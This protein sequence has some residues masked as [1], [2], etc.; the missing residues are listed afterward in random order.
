VENPEIQRL[1]ASPRLQQQLQ[2]ILEVDKLKTIL[3]QSRLIANG[4]RENSA[5]HS[6][7]LALMVMILAEHANEPADLLHTMKLVIVHDIVEIDAGDTFAYD[8]D[9][10]LDKREREEQAARRLFGILPADQAAEL[11]ALWH[12]FE[13]QA[14]PEARLANAV[15]RLMPLMHN[16]FTRG[17]SWQQHGVTRPQV[18]DRV[19]AIDDGS[20]ELW[21]FAAHLIDQAVA[22]GILA[23]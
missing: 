15:D 22:E 17:G 9:G 21:D 12:E 13:E 16:Y 14:T 4:R 20:H 7:H 5:E 8:R 11:H 18:I 23:P 6:W 19:G 2:F 1:Q 10:A 3:R